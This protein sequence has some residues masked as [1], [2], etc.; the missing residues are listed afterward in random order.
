[1]VAAV[2]T[3]GDELRGGGCNFAS[4]AKAGSAAGSAAAAGSACRIS[5]GSGVCEQRNSDGILCFSLSLFS[6]SDETNR[7]NQKSNRRN[8]ET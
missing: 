4:G 6:S 5:G 7:F 3:G 1:M 2:S 8:L